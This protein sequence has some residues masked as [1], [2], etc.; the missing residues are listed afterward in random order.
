M[1]LYNYANLWIGRQRSDLNAV[2]QAQGFKDLDEKIQKITISISEGPK[3]FDDLRALLQTEG[4][5][6][7]AHVT[8]AFQ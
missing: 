1:K 6:T 3:R 2:Q 4:E 7:R 5:L 8:N